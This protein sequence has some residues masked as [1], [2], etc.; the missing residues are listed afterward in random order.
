MN[1]NKP[2]LKSRSKNNHWHQG[3]FIPTHPEKYIGNARNILY[4]SRWERIFLQ[5]CD[6]TDAVIRYSSE[7]CIIPYVSP[8]DCKQHRYFVDFFVSILQEDGTV[9]N[10]LVEIKP[11]SQTIPPKA[12]KKHPETSESYQEAV[13]T[14]LVN[15]AKWEQ[16]KKVCKKRNWEFMILTENELFRTRKKK[17]GKNQKRA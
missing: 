6:T 5:W 2:S 15:Q 11:F 17:Y 4:R 7:E 14:F 16:A 13:R 3:V 1:M 10:F 9:K 12:T 8:I